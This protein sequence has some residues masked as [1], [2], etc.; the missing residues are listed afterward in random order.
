MTKEDRR[1][2]NQNAYTVF[3]SQEG[4]VFL[5]YLEDFFFNTRSYTEGD[6]YATAFREGQREVVRHIHNMLG[7]KPKV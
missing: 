1:A 3:T 7:R 2:A 6:P 4:K 5:K